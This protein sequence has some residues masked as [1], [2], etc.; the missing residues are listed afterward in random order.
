MKRIALLFAGQGAQTVGMGKDLV[1]KYSA[2]ARVFERA[3]TVLGRA[4]SKVTFE[5]PDD[6]LTKTNN[7]Q[8]ALYLHG[9]ACLEVLREQPFGTMNRS[10]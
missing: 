2:A 7:C 4:I 10:H 1:E 3:D 9:L 6:D 8:P 5:G